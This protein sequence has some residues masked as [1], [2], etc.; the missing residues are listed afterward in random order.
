MW[1]LGHATNRSCFWA[2]SCYQTEKICHLLLEIFIS[3]ILVT[4]YNLKNNCL[5]YFVSSL[6]RFLWFVPLQWKSLGLAPP[7]HSR[8]GSQAT[9]YI[10]YFLFN[11][12]CH[13]PL[14]IDSTWNFVV[15]LQPF[16]KQRVLAIVLRSHRWLPL[17]SVQENCINQTKTKPNNSWK[18][19]CFTY[20]ILL[21]KKMCLSLFTFG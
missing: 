7:L 12:G 16:S 18:H 6:S 19:S 20:I 5:A 13:L 14:V 1:Q 15:L 10:V 8:S 2:A 3:G 9:L 17:G 11:S 21:L 4:F